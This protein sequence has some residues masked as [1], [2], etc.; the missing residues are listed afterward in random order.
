MN[1]QQAYQQVMIF[2]ARVYPHLYFLSKQFRIVYVPVEAEHTPIATDGGT[3]ILTKSWV[4]RDLPFRIVSFMHELYHNM[5]QHPV[6]YEKLLNRGE[7]PLLAML[8]F[9]AKVNYCVR[10]AMLLKNADVSLYDKYLNTFGI[11]EEY[12]E[13]LSVEEIIELLKEESELPQPTFGNDVRPPKEGD[14]GGRS[15]NSD[16]DRKENE[17]EGGGGQGGEGEGENGGT[18]SSGSGVGYEGDGEETQLPQPVI[19]NEGNTKLVNAK[20]SKD[21]ENNLVEAVR[22]ALI[23]AKIAGTQ[24]TSIEERVLREITKPKVKWGTILRNSVISYVRELVINTWRFRNRRVPTL[25]GCQPIHKPKAW[26]F[27]DLSGSITDEEFDQF[28]SETYHMSKELSEIT[29]ITW[30]TEVTG[31]YD[32]KNREKLK[33]I[34]FKGGGG[35]KFA[36]VLRQYLKQIHSDDVLICLTDGYWS[37]PDEA[38]RILKKIRAYKI[39]VTTGITQSGFDKIIKIRGV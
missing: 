14:K 16:E 18:G 11:P 19:L 26:V 21:L 22:R 20:T 25:P 9:D 37:D 39:L 4:C 35:T 6:R 30:D 3:I 7:D 13:K 10:Q 1:P 31:V 24:L 32:I 36:P 17:S 2:L 28:V 23:S 5:L 29:L 27:A 8:A 34:K 12:L 33:T 38:C 15:V